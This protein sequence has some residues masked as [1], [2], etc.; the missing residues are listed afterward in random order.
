[1]W[2]EKVSSVLIKGIKYNY[3][4]K[5]SSTKIPLSIE[6]WPQHPKDSTTLA[7]EECMS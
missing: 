3:H 1:M 4:C 6:Y 2:E 7:R 5:S